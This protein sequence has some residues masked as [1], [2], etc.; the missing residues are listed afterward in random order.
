[1]SQLRDKIIILDL[2]NLTHN[3]N[4]KLRMIV[5]PQSLV[6]YLQLHATPGTIDQIQ[7]SNHDYQNNFE[8]QF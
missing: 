1:M 6:K 4:H 3:V 7:F 8:P 5:A 2:V